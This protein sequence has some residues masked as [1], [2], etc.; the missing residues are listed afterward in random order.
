MKKMDKL[1]NNLRINK[2]MLIFLITLGLIG[3]IIGSL[4]TVS[5]KVNDQTLVKNY[6]NTYLVNID[7]DKLDYLMALKNISI[8]NYSYVII[9]WLLGISIIGIPIIV[10]MYFMKFFML[11]FTLSSII[12]NYKLKGLILAFIYIFPHQ[13]INITIYTFLII[14]SLTLALKIGEAF[15]KKKS[16]NFKLIINR[17]SKVLIITLFVI[18]LT[19]LYEIYIMPYLIK[20]ILPIIN[21]WI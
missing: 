15:I 8:N 7:K 3:L 13:L 5:L 2:K 12:I 10:F 16:I 9:V 20:L 4:F 14:F 11:G 19:N 21:T 1:I 17:Y 6:L 18:T